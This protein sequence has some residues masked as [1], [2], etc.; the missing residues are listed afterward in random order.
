MTASLQAL[1]WKACKYCVWS[2]K[3]CLQRQNLCCISAIWGCSDCSDVGLQLSHGAQWKLVRCPSSNTAKVLLLAGMNQLLHRQ[4]E[5]SGEGPGAS[6]IASLCS[7]SHLS[8]AALVHAT[9]VCAWHRYAS[10]HDEVFIEKLSRL[11]HVQV[12]LWLVP[13]TQCIFSCF[14]EAITQDTRKICV[15]VV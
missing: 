15:P 10:L 3:H 9:T 4:L 2:V 1:V 5:R 8:T 6:C 11:M 12:Q 14:S 7:C 13:T